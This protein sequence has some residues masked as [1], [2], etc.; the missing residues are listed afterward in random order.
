MIPIQLPCLTKVELKILASDTQDEVAYKNL[1]MNQL[2]W[3]NQYKEQIVNQA[4]KLYTLIVTG[5]ARP[6]LSR[7]C[8][9][10]ALDENLCRQQI[11]VG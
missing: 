4:T 10:F 8:C 11:A 1:L 3:C 9:N 5:K 2:S 6:E 7:R